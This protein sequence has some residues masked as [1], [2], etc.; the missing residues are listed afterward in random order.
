[1]TGSYSGMGI[2]NK[3]RKKKSRDEK[4]E[5][6]CLVKDLGISLVSNGMPL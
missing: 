3:S 1:M 5:V 4:Y 6:A 2:R